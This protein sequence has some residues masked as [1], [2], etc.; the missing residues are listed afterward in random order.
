MIK[1]ECF[2]EAYIRRQT[3]ELRA[4][5]RLLPEKSIHAFA[6]LGHLADSGLPFVFKGGTSAMLLLD[7]IRRLSIDIDIQCGESRATVD[8]VLS[9]IATKPPF[10]GLAPDERGDRGLPRRRHFLF[11]FR[12]IETRQENQYIQLDIV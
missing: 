7:P 9:T 12:S 3:N 2:S 4:N 6:L 1:A 8:A 10:V 5:D 11:Y